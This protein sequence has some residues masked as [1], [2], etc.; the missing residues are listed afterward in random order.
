MAR[1]IAKARL[2]RLATAVPFLGAG[3]AVY[4]ERQTYTEWQELYPEGTREDYACDMAIL[5]AEVF[6]EVFVSVSWLPPSGSHPDRF[7]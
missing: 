4:F 3:A 6:D 7:F 5:T 2:R 1:A